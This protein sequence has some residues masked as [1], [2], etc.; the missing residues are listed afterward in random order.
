MVEILGFTFVALLLGVAI[1]ED[2]RKRQ[3]PP[4]QC[5]QCYASDNRRY[6]LL[7]YICTITNNRLEGTW[8][9][10]E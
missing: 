7:C 4:A 8:R 5:G 10:H 3:T 9:Y 2:D 1:N 6:R